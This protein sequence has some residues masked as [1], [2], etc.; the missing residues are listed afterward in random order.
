MGYFVRKIVAKA[1]QKVAQ[2]GHTANYS[3]SNSRVG[4]LGKKVLTDGL[5]IIEFPDMK[6]GWTTKGDLS[7][8][9]VE[10]DIKKTFNFVLAFFGKYLH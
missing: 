4:G 10:R 1:F 9:E 2:S 8:P 3:V 6:H 5:E 7:V